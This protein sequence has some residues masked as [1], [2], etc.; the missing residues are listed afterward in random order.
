MVSKFYYIFLDEKSE[1]DRT[2]KYSMD[3]N[4]SIIL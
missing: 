1:E 2:N 3:G 4:Q